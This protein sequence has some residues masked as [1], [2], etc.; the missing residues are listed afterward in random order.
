MALLLDPSKASIEIALE[1]WK[2]FDLDGKRNQLDSQA[3]A[4]TDAQATSQGTRKKLAEQTRGKP[5]FQGR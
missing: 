5:F 4:V 1:K 2:Q 3:T